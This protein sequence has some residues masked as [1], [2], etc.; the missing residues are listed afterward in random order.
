MKAIIEAIALMKADPEGTKSVIAEYLLLDL[1][2]NA[3]DLED[4]YVNTVQLT[5]RSYPLPSPEGL[6]TIIDSNSI[7]N[8]AVADLTPQQ[9][10]DLTILE[11][12]EASGFL[13]GLD[14]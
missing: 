7:D 5:L 6:Q 1:V 12:I 4:A 11:E 2:E 13:S 10:I 9:L 14:Q 3:D 8:P